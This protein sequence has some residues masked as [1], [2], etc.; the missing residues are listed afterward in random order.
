MGL[1][2]QKVIIYTAVVV[3]IYFSPFSITFHDSGLYWSGLFVVFRFHLIWSVALASANTFTNTVQNQSCH[4]L[5]MAF[6]L[7]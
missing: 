7:L 3:V 5:C 2:L 6:K 4:D 1:L